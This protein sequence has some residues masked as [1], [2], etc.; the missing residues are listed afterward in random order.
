MFSCFVALT[1]EYRKQSYDS[2]VAFGKKTDPSGSYIRK[3]IPKL[4][5]Y[6]D[7]FI[8][9]PWLAPKASQKLW[10][11]EIG[12][13]YPV[14][15]CDH[16]PTSKENMSKMQKAYAVMKASKDNIG[17][18]RDFD[19]VSSRSE[20]GKQNKVVEA[21]ES[22]TVTGKKR[23]AGITGSADIV[24]YFEERRQSKK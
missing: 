23:K 4:K 13:D 9:E 11:C 14:P 2:P 19:G 18:G 7:K 24:S 10:G 15:I 22:K 6:P 1:F 20:D 21:S 12:K 17:I 5:N 8:Y 16:S 3:Y